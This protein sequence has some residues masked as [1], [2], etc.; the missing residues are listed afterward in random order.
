MV[1]EGT[2]LQ[3]CVNTKIALYYTYL[4]LR[5]LQQIINACCG[6]VVKNHWHAFEGSNAF[7]NT[8]LQL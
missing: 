6:K 4:L 5:V 2:T 7:D 8:P 1:H 3:L